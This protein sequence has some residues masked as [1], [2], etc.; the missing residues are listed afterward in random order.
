MI[1]HFDARRSIASL[2]TTEQAIAFA[3]I[4]WLAVAEAAIQEKGRFCVAL[5][6][7]STPKAIYARL[8][9]FPK[10]ID[11]TRVH[12]YWSDERPVPP[13]HPDSNYHMAMTSGLF[14]LPIPP[15]QIHR[16]KAESHI[17][18]NAREYQSL[19]QSLGPGLFDLVMLGVGED[20]HTASLFPNTTAV[21]QHEPLVVANPIPDKKTTRMTLTFRA[22]NQSAF[23]TVYA[24]GPAKHA[25]VKKVL[26]TSTY[27]ASLIGTPE[28]PALWI[29]DFQIG[30]SL[31]T[32]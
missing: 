19:L 18:E 32:F 27:P 15:T 9:T 10:A 31:K 24:L 12:L 8:S 23:A 13:E 30:S 21:R 16:M 11:W 26:T 2:P 28:H 14:T 22:I 25:I 6:G 29:L 20:G 17:E 7:G 3:A 1:K 5:S 4:H